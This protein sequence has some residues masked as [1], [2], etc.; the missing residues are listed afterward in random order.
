[1]TSSKNKPGIRARMGAFFMRVS[2]TLSV[3]SEK[4]TAR[5]CPEDSSNQ[6]SPWGGHQKKSSHTEPVFDLLNCGPRNRFAV[7]TANGFIIAHNCQYRTGWS[8]LQKQAKDVYALPLSDGDAAFLVDAYRA[9][10]RE[11]VAFWHNTE[12]AAE[13][14]VDNPGSVYSIGKAAYRFDGLHLQCRL[15]SGRKITYPYATMETV[16]HPEYGPKRQLHYMCEDGPGKVWRKISTHGGVLTNHIVQGTSGCLLRYACNN[17][18]AAGFKVILRIYDEIVAE[19]PDAS[20]FDEFQR[21]ILQLPEWA[22]G[23]PVSGAGWVAECY[24][25]D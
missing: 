23:L 7:R 20:R 15:A 24:K 18:E 6:S 19:M 1:M 8:T 10:H 14:A 11:N 9:T 2:T 12:K 16:V 3:A 5:T 22:E 4:R 17:L 21:I 25:K 13:K